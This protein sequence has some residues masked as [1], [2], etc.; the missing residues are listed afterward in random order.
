[1]EVGQLCIKLAGRDAGKKCV[2][3]DILDNNFVLIDGETRRRKCNIMHLEPL[4]QKID[5]KK[6]ASHETIIEVFK[7][8]GLEARISKPKTQ[9]KKV[10]S[11]RVIKI[12]PKQA[13]KIINEVK[14][15]KSKEA[16][17]LVTKKTISKAEKKASINAS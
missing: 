11:K 8:L 10:L 5:I 3:V 17:K 16:Q 14:E 9:A 12:K 13:N 6:E 1:M 15:E 4:N 2:I 7:K